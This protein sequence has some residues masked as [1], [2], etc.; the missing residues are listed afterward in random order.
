MV[1]DLIIEEVKDK[2]SRG[3]DP[4]EIKQH[5]LSKGWSDIDIDQALEKVNEKENKE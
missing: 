3:M 2:I 1:D 5:L 4:V